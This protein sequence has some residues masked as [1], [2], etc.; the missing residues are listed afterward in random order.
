MNKIASMD[1]ILNLFRLFFLIIVFFSVVSLARAFIVEKIDLFEI[2]SK[3]L[4][5]RI[6]FSDKIS[7]VD[8]DT[9]RTYVGIIDLAKFTSDDFAK[10]LLNSIYY[11]KINSEASAKIVLKDL[12]ANQGY[13]VFYEKFYNK[14]LYDEKK[15]LVEAKL[16]GAG[17]AKRLDTS[18]YVLIKDKDYFRR[19]MLNVE[20]I[21]PNR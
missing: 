17:A 19:G 18:F 4:N 16:T 9:G 5:Y 10:N 20:A 15:V 8:S 3:L 12:D 21:L 2:E 7:Y 11:G 1:T 13:D 14:E 6:A